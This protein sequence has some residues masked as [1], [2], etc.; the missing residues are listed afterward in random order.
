MNIIHADS[1]DKKWLPDKKGYFLIKVDRERK[2]IMLALCDYKNAIQK[3]FAGR[4]PTDIL[5]LLHNL[6]LVSSFYHA[7]Y[8]GIELEKAYIAVHNDLIYIQDE[9]LD[10]D[11]KYVKN[12]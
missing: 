2:E 9:D 12:I 1:T 3:V 7:T 5:Y 4:H 10:F 6:D 11:K 8:L